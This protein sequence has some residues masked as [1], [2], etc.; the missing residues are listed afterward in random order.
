MGLFSWIVMTEL[1]VH[2]AVVVVFQLCV[3]SLQC[4]YLR[5]RLF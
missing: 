2:P 1:N 4:V 3:Y 5:H